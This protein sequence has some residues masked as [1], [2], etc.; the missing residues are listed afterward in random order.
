[1]RALLD[2]NIVI[3]REARSNR[4]SQSIGI[5]F[6]WLEKAKYEKC[7][8]PITV[9]E[10]KNNSNQN[11]LND[12]KRKLDNYSV[13]KTI[14]PLSNEVQKVSSCTDKNKNDLNDTKLLNEVFQNRVDILI[15]EDRKIHNKALSLNIQYKVYNIDS[16]LAKIVSENPNLINYNVL[17][18]KKEYFGNIDL[19]DTFFDSFR[20]DYEGFDKWFNKKA[21]EI[22]YVTYNKKK[23][24]SFLYVKVEENTENYFDI[25][26]VFKPKKRLKIGTF[27]VV[28]NGVRLG[29][30][31]LKIIFD[32]AI[33]YKVDEIYVTIFKKTDEQN[34]LIDLLKNWG[35]V[36]YGKK[37]GS[38]LVLVRDFTPNISLENP[39]KTYPYISA[40]QSVFLC[41]IYPEYHTEL[42]LI[43]F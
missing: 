27:K 16:F 32:N 31:F 14:A 29:E 19:K 24:L 6:S 43:L 34:R 40:N 20:S 21:D 23:L 35:F 3:H 38:E 28:S 1:M 9:D 25:D 36:E 33:Q 10:L 42:F 17:S 30:R 26:P 8:H 5:L 12:L 18:V 11:S 13:L 22:A 2:T 39:K 41:P 37:R 15:S 7:I 4:A